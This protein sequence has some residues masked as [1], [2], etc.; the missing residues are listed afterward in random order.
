[1]EKL[2]SILTEPG[3]KEDMEALKQEDKRAIE[4]FTQDIVDLMKAKDWGR[5]LVESDEWVWI[6]QTENAKFF[7]EQ[8]IEEK[9]KGVLNHYFDLPKQQEASIKLKMS[10]ISLTAK[11]MLE[12]RLAIHELTRP[13]SDSPGIGDSPHAEARHLHLG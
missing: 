5:F 10:L 6:L 8:K 4:G 12:S 1:M 9:I 7:N 11:I 13:E 3:I 2:Q